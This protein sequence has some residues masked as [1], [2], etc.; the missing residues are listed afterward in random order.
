M[1]GKA[2]GGKRTKDANSASF[3]EDTAKKT[4]QSKRKV[5]LDRMGGLP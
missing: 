4:G 1:H 2:G 5:Q 3:A